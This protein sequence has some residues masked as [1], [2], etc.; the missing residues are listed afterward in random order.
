MKNHINSRITITDIQLCSMYLKLTVGGPLTQ[1]NN[2]SYRQTH[3]SDG[4][5]FHNNVMYLWA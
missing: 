5:S 2:L 4:V 3:I 1:T